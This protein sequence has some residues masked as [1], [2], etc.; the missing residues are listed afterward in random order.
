MYVRTGVTI[1]IIDRVGNYYVIDQ[2]SRG[3]CAHGL[4]CEHRRPGHI[5][6]IPVISRQDFF[7]EL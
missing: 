1:I 5:K 3:W 4:Y 2:L 7:M 6:G